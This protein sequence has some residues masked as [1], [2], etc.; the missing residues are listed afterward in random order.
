VQFEAF[1]KDELAGLIF[2]GDILVSE[3]NL[4]QAGHNC[5]RPG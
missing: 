5:G 4:V 2:V 1:L 3:S